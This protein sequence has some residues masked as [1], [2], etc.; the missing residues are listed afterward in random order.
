MEVAIIHMG[1]P[2]QIL[3][4]TSV[5]RRIREKYPSLKITWVS[6]KE[7]AYLLKHNKKINKSIS[8]EDF[9]SAPKEYDLV[10]N[11][12]PIFPFTKDCQCKCKNLMGFYFDGNIDTLGDILLDEKQNTNI[13]IYQ[14]YYKILGMEWRGEGCQL[15]YFPKSK[16]KKG[17]IG[18]S[19][20]NA[21]LR[22]YILDNLG[23]DDTKIYYVPYRKN[24]FKRMDEIN[25][26]EKIVTDDFIT[27]Y[28]AS[29]L[30]KYVYFLET[31]PSSTKLEFFGKGEIHKVKLDNI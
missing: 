14:L 24:I 26:C 27:M 20:A 29:Y 9:I 7:Y 11:L 31:F 8:L 2:I 15:S 12:Y 28:L 4:S 30:R 13:N 22:N 6:K 21:N 25:K 3:P 1:N 10:A 19:V 23:V 16:S 17:R 18:V 5:L